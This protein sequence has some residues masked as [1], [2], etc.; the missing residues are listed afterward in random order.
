MIEKIDIYFYYGLYNTIKYPINIPNQHKMNTLKVIT[1]TIFIITC[2]VTTNAHAYECKHAYNDK[3]LRSNPG[4]MT[5]KKDHF[6]TSRRG[7]DRPQLECCGEYCEHGP[8]QINYDAS[9]YGIFKWRVIGTNREFETRDMKFNCD[10]YDFDDDLVISKSSCGITYRMIKSVT[11]EEGIRF[12]GWIVCGIFTV[13]LMCDDSGIGAM[14][15]KKYPG[16]LGNFLWDLSIVITPVIFWLALPKGYI[17]EEV[18]PFIINVI[19]WCHDQI[20]LYTQ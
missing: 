17:Y 14:I 5:F 7:K 11:V 12:F 20:I 3:A 13:S 4:K 15:I 9:Q 8:I 19:T 18:K 1:L 10:G 2:L 16:P 6:T